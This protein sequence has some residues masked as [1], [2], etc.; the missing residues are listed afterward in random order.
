M[1]VLDKG[2]PFGLGIV[3]VLQSRVCTIILHM[4]WCLLIAMDSGFL[5]MNSW[6]PSWVDSGS[7]WDSCMLLAELRW[8]PW[9]NADTASVKGW[10]KGLRG[11]RNP[12]WS[13]D[14]RLAV[15]LLEKSGPAAASA[16]F[17]G[18]HL[19]GVVTFCSSIFLS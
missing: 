5:P 10:W 1:L 7:P 8:A 11:P 2:Q 17:T 19:D 4:S 3:P 6:I 9:Q 18:S 13:H 12:A 14:N 16:G 15:N